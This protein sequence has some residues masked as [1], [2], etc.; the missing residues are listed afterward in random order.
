MTENSPRPG[1]VTQHAG[2]PRVPGLID[3]SMAVDIG[4]AG[5]VS[6]RVVIGEDAPAGKRDLL[7]LIISA[8]HVRH[9][10]QA[11]NGGRDCVPA[12]P[13][14]IGYSREA[15]ITAA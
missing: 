14:H 6:L 3:G 1:P 11:L 4:P 15:V 7:E 10:S 13:C 2:L 8:E 9:L 5:S 12:F